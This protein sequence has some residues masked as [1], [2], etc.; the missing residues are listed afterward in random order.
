MKKLYQP[1]YLIL[2][3][4]FLLYACASRPHPAEQTKKK[5]AVI[6]LPP[7]EGLPPPDNRFERALEKIKQNGKDVDKY[8]VE[9]HGRIIVKAG[10]RDENGD[11]EIVYDLENTK[12]FGNSAYEVGFSCCDKESGII[13]KDA[14]VWNPL[15]ADG[16]LLLSFD[17]NYTDSWERHFDLFDKY[18][19]RVTFFINGKTCA[20]CAKALNRGH[21]VG[22]HSFS[23][24]DLRAMSREEFY[25][26]AI[27][28]ARA[29]REAG[30]P[31]LSF[32]YPYGFYEPWMHD[33]LLRSF[34]A[35]RGYGVTYHLYS[36]DQIGR[37]YISSRAI[38][39]TVIPS[40]EDF[41]RIAGLMLKTVKFL[42]KKLLLPLTTHDISAS[43]QWGISPRRLEFLLKTANEL[44]MTFYRYS[45]FAREK[46]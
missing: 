18:T 42:D 28:P 23:H 30:V 46:K 37:G 38:D 31:L 32:A 4:A 13:L 21:D 20:F 43:A 19:A 22:Y 6:S 40:D 12:A 9:D 11:F 27:E 7:A 41:F 34:G 17:D 44:G 39:N 3:P 33:V 24:R 8:F 26:E 25:R 36:E 1:Y 35:L 29:F 5:P 16:G 2:F 15:A 10:L 14:L 45:D